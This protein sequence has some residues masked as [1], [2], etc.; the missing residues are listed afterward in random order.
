MFRKLEKT[1]T[2]PEKVGP[3]VFSGKFQENFDAPRKFLPDFPG[4]RNAVPA[5]VWASS[6]HDNGSG[7]VGPQFGNAPGI[8]LLSPPQPS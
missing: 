2:V 3:E 1:V 7:K 5:R 6:W 4:L 8:F